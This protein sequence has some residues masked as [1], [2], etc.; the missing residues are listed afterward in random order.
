MHTA[1]LSSKGQI[2][3]PKALRNEL[4]LLPGT[5][6][7]LS[8]DAGRL[9]LEPL[10]EPEFDLEAIHAAVDVLAGCLHRPDAVATS[11]PE[12][13]AAIVALLGAEDRRMGRGQP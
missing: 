10:R 8:V 1:S 13:A 6:F 9:V 12:D 3:I 11:A 5:R 4:N 2:V 7:E